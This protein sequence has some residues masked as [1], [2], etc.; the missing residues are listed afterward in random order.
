MTPECILISRTDS[1]GDVVL[2]LPVAG[3][4]KKYLPG[5][6][7]IF[8][9][10]T[11]TEP[12]VKLS[13]HVD[14]FLNWDHIENLP[15]SRQAAELRKTDADTIV[16]IFPNIQIAKAAGRA[17]IAMRIGTSHRWYHYLYCNKTVNFSRRKSELHE[18]QLNFSLLNSLGIPVVPTLTEITRFYGMTPEALT[19]DFI[20]QLTAG[21]RFNLILH[22]RSKG[23]AREWGLDNCAKLIH[24]LPK[25]TY[26]IFI[27]GT[28]EEGKSMKSFLE[29]Q[30]DKI[31]DLT[32]KFTLPQFINFIGKA[33]GI[34]AA[35]TGPLHIAAA[36]GKIAVGLYAPMHPIHP[37]RWAPI[38]KKAGYLVLNKTCNVCRKSMDCKCIKDIQPEQVIKKLEELAAK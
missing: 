7:I 20:D 31:T 22:P 17:G 25:E 13:A 19:E 27:T 8:L 32:G 9:G 10:R 30:A 12:V 24:L 21:D 6:K 38:G 26:N 11:Y 15:L 16:H 18:A 37:G 29:E 2:T 5:C 3:A 1:I 14:E 28:A 35:S 36:L 23:S 4:I 33:D 34:V